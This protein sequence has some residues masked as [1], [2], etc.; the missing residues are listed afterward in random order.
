M[1]RRCPNIVA[2]I[3]IA[4]GLS[5]STNLHGQS[6]EGIPTIIDGED[7]K[8]TF[9]VAGPKGSALEILNPAFSTCFNRD[10]MLPDGLNRYLHHTGEGLVFFTDYTGVTTSSRTKYSRTEL[11]EMRGSEECNWTL[12]EGGA[13]NARLKVISLAGGA[14]KIIFMQIHGKSPE[15]KPLLKCIWEKGRI[16]LLTKSG[17]KLKDLS[18]KRQYADIALNEWFTCSIRVNREFLRIRI[19]GET[20]ETFGPEVLDCWPEGNTY[21]F[22]VGNYLQ[23]N[24]AG[25]GA[26]VVF[27]SIAVS[28][29]SAQSA[30]QTVL[31][32]CPP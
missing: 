18:R 13:L 8:I 9:P 11:R 20:V 17:K 25:A 31:P 5:V 27:S 12:S 28:H 3:V 30:V 7:W 21:Y 14:N 24:R 29:P 16:R 1:N 22:K 26:T 19:N 6:G 23:H 4:L 15:S 10:C 2:V 32:A